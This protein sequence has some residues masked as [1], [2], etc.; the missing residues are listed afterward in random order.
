MTMREWMFAALL[1]IALG[2]T[3]RSNAQPGKDLPA[4]LDSGETIERWLFLGR[5]T[6]TA[7][8]PP[9]GSI[10][11]PDYPVKPGNRVMV[12]RHALVYGS[13]DCKVVDAAD[14][15][16]EEDVAN[17]VELVRAGEQGLEITGS[18]IECP[19]ICGA[20]TVWV[21]VRIPAARLIRIDH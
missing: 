9:S 11:P 5:R 7:W 6:E 17:A 16:A 15:R 3:A 14:F 20:K 2:I 18:P 13:V 12:K 21:N 1:V 19:S 4:R 8:Q 10:A